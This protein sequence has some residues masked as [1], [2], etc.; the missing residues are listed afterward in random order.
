MTEYISDQA[1]LASAAGA[2]ELVINDVSDTTDDAGGTPK[3]IL[4]RNLGLLALQTTAETASF[5]AEVGVMHPCDVGASADILVTFPSSPSAG[6]MFGYMV[7]DQ[8]TSAGPFDT[9]NAPGY[10]V[11]PTGAPVINNTTYPSNPTNGTNKWGLFLEGESLIFRYYDATVGWQVWMDGRIPHFTVSAGS[12]SY[13]KTTSS[14]ENIQNVTND[15]DNANCMT[16]A[17]YR[18]QAKRGGSYYWV[19]GGLFYDADV[20]GQQTQIYLNSSTELCETGQYPS[21]SYQY[22]HTVQI[23]HSPTAADAYTVV[24]TGGGGTQVIDNVKLEHREVLVG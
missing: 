11:E 8:S 12:S 16:A 24:H 10:G 15:I 4:A 13:T 17:Q 7:I 22:S 21:G 1:A 3:K 23:L 14:A 2:D 5:T 6:D 18:I 19:V 20:A 9:D